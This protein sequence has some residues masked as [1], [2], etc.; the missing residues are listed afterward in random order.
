MAVYTNSRG[1]LVLQEDSNPA[2][3]SHDGLFIEILAQ[4]D[5]GSKESTD[6]WE[7]WA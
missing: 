1:N 6:W 3:P 4:T 2:R 7:T 5:S